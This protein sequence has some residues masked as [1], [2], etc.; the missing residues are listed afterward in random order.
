[1]D[2][3]IIFSFARSG[4]TLVN[5][6]L[7][8]HPNCLVLSEVNPAGAV[9]S[10]ARQAAEWLG[11]I[12]LDEVDKFQELCYAE[13]IGL[14]Y[15]KS[16]SEKKSLFIRDWVT[17]NYLSGA[18][19]SSI[20]PSGVLEQSLYM[21]RGE[22]SIKPLVI[23]RKASDVYRSIRHNFSQ[24]ADLSAD[25]FASAYLAYAN[26][27]MPFPKFSLEALQ[28]SPRETLVQLLQLLGLSIEYVDMQLVNFADFRDCT[29]NTTLTKPAPTTFARRIEPAK[30][31]L[32]HNDD[33]MVQ[34]E[35]IEADRLMGYRV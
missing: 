8:V 25:D 28:S 31:A 22:Y 6:L 15:E 7:G 10:I 14:L 30:S 16:I 26:A 5:Q 20:V 4:G 32:P 2:I 13:Q 33:C 19:G 27:V 35:F 29:G 11:L 24:F 9:V 23:T 1:M 17:V 3:P 18:G 12:E 21:T 34:K